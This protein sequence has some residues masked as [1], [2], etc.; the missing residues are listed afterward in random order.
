M[1]I[2]DIMDD[3]PVHT[4]VNCET[5]EIT[6]TPL[7]DQEVSDRS[8]TMQESF[9]AMQADMTEQDQLLNIVKS[10]TNPETKALAKLLGL[11]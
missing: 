8:K 7:T 9:L 4:V 3:R 2:C 1:D 6:H 10:S 5:G 11:T